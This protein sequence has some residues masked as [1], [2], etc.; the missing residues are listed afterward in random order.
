MRQ[1]NSFPAFMELVWQ[2]TIN[3]SQLTFGGCLHVPGP[4]EVLFIQSPS[5]G[6]EWHFEEQLF[7]VQDVWHVA[8]FNISGPAPC[9]LW[10]PSPC[11]TFVVGTPPNKCPLT[12]KNAPLNVV[13]PPP[14]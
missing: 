9:S 12:V 3:K 11:L 5:A 6:V 2:G 7:V 10:L 1:T 8:R 14:L 4:V 13:Q